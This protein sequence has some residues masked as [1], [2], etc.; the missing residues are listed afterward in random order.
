VGKGLINLKTDLKSLKYQGDNGSQPPFV[1]KDINNPPS[2]SRIAQEVNSRVDDVVRVTQAILPTNSRFLENQAKLSQFDSEIKLNPFSK[3]LKESGLSFKQALIQRVKETAKNLA[4]TSASTVAQAGVAGTGTRFGIGFQKV[5]SAEA[6]QGET[7]TPSDKLKSGT[8]RTKDTNLPETELIK[9]QNRPDSPFIEGKILTTEEKKTGTVTIPVKTADSNIKDNPGSALQKADV[10]SFIDGGGNIQQ[11]PEEDIPSTVNSQNSPYTKLPY[12]PLSSQVKRGEEILIANQEDITTLKGKKTALPNTNEPDPGTLTGARG[13]VKTGRAIKL[14]DF[15]AKTPSED[16]YN[17]GGSAKY[18]KESR[19][20]LGDQGIRPE[21]PLNYTKTREE[22][23]DRLNALDVFESESPIIA[24]SLEEGRDLIKFRFQVITPESNAYLFFRAYLTDFS[25]GYR[26]SWSETKYIGRGEAMQTYDGFSRD[27]SLG[28]KIAASTRAEM[29][30]LYRKMVYLASTTAPT[31]ATSEN[32][33]RGTFVRLTV[34]SYL[35]EVPGVITSVDYKWQTDYPWEI[36][37][38]NPEGG[39][40]DDMQELPHVMDCSISFKPIHDFI[41]QTGLQ[42][43]I[44]NP[45][46]ASGGRDFL[47]EPIRKI[48]N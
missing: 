5:N 34:G 16:R 1:T 20:G 6:L 19:V 9:D 3:S 8:L 27:I 47:K 37:F 45:R 38:Q 14:F 22:S 42:H 7:I 40:D 26:G 30:P 13:E 23:K 46:T 31:Y 35:Y 24:R 28:F 2:N 18:V 43:Y 44:T 4:E 10:N 21:D 41:P 33:M 15:R 39:I 17:G 12:Q 11:T 25:D 29:E 32:F 36:A 48:K